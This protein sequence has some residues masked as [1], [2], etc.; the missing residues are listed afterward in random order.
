M[1]RD[2]IAAGLKKIIEIPIRIG[3]HQVGIKRKIRQPPQ[4]RN[5]H[6]AIREVRHEVAI[7]HIQMQQ[8]R[9]GIVQQLDL[10]PQIAEVTLQHRRSDQGCYASELF[11]D[12]SSTHRGAPRIHKN[13]SPYRGRLTG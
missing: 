10:S 4:R 12:G 11:E 2:S 9:T 6:G 3:N 7:H 1:N 8:A 5:H 13:Q